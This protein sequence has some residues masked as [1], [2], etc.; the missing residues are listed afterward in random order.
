MLQ[1]GECA[2]NKTEIDKNTDPNAIKITKI[3]YNYWIL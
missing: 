3:I 1:R 2:I